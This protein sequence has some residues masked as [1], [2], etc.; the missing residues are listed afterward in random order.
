MVGGYIAVRM[1]SKILNTSISNLDSTLI[2]LFSGLFGGA[3]VNIIIVLSFNNSENKRGLISV[4]EKNW[5]LDM[6]PIPN[7]SEILPLIL[8]STCL[9]ILIVTI[10]FSIV[11]SL[12][13]QVVYKKK[14]KL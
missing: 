10:L 3:C 12:I 4:L 2:G 9:V 1:S 5:P 14:F 11:G 8:L 7:F 6:Q 13:A